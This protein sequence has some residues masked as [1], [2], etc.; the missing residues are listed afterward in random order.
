MKLFALSLALCA[1]VFA[2]EE[3]PDK[4]LRHSAATF[5][6]IMATPDKSIP[7]DLLHHAECVVIV[8]GMK[9]AAFVVGGEYGKGF[10]VCRTGT[11]WSGPSAVRL[12][13]GSV[14][15]QLGADSTDVVLLIMNEKGLHH[16][17]SDKFTIGVDATAAAGPVGRE[18]KADTD[19]LLHAEVLSWS[20]SRGLFAGVSL[21]GTSVESDKGENE[22]LYGRAEP[23]NAILRGEV[24]T[25]EATRALTAELDEYAG[26]QN[27]A[28][29]Q[30]GNH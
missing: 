13:G 9:K 19:V 4:R 6:E 18:A 30:K 22:K 5:R 29:R 26:H 28:D 24:R 25:P 10:A 12:A 1:L 17:L 20:R 7:R 23:H 3:T 2:Q 21:N 16:M 27:T 15:L 8:P 11:G 14:G